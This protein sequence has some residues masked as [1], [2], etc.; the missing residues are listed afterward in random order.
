MIFSTSGD[1]VKAVVKK[2]FLKTHSFYFYFNYLV[3]NWGLPLAAMADLKKGY[4][5]DLITKHYIYS[6]VI[7][8]S[9]LFRPFNNFA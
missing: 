7:F 3:A 1:Q 5:P 2:L 8:Y 4:Q 6:I 9:N